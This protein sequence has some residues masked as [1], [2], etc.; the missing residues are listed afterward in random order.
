M[1]MSR[2]AFLRGAA[3]GAAACALPLELAA[4]EAYG[5]FRMGMQTYTLRDY[6]FEQALGILK[7]LGLKY[8][9]F[10]GG[11]H[12]PVTDNPAKID[13]AKEKLKAA[14]VQILSWGVQGFTKNVD[15]TKKAF[16]FAKAMGFSVYS[17]NPS[18]DSFESLATLT[19]EY[20]IKI[21]IHNHGPDDKTYGRLEQLLKAVEKWPV[22]IGACVDTG[23]VL[24]AGED[25]VQWIKALGPRVHDVHLKDYVGPRGEDERTL[26]KGKLD[27]VA[28]LKALQ[29]VKF[30]G[31]LA[32]EYE[33]N[34]PK[35]LDDLKICLA[36]VREAAQKL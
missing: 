2:R 19:K 10:I 16:E 26:G 1:S 24:R 18:A 7:D 27:V 21:A 23:H 36:A 12:L 15:N 3:A 6:N 20:G 33:V 32:L 30:S 11:K 22:E 17:A 34:G 25:P 28:T 9:E 31:N 29:E 4:Q 13:E 5:G 35:L 8:A 14:G